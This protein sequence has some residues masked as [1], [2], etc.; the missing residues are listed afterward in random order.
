VA[1]VFPV[2]TPPPPGTAP[3]L[4]PA[5][6]VSRRDVTADIGVILFVAGATLTALGALLPDQSGTS[7][8]GYWA[9]TA[10]QLITAGVVYVLA[11]TRTR[12]RWISAAI[13]V[14]GVIAVTVPLYF[15]GSKGGVPLAPSDLFYTWPALYV[16]Y[17]FRRRGIALCLGLIAVSYGGALFATGA[18]EAAAGTA[19]TRWVATV[20]VATG[21]A[22]AMHVLRRHVDGLVDR[23]RHVAQID[24]LTKLFNR[25]AFDQ[26]FELELERARRSDGPMALVLGDID[27]FKEL[28]DR[29]GH[30]AGDQALIAVGQGLAYGCR[31]LDTVA[32]IG[33]EE[34]ALLLPGEDASRGVEAAERMRLQVAGVATGA[35][36]LTMSFGVV[37]FPQDGV[38][39]AQ[40]LETADRALYRA[41]ALGRNRVVAAAE[42]ATV[43]AG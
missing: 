4:S 6:H 30:A 32:R 19:A 34:F 12:A 29:H 7:V 14:A 13:V 41:K 1:K 8:A 43:P 39:P 35:E 3:T 38:T 37:A 27:N 10:F 31:G 21:A 36:G 20:A 9:D 2:N 26:R 22:A 24:P 28:N 11:A 23:L 40:L 17:F 42:A 25:R 33:G 16:G 5:P 18:V 15:S